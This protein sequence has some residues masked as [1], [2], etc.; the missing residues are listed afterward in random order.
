MKVQDSFEVL[1]GAWG[2]L[3]FLFSLLQSEGV[4]MSAGGLASRLVPTLTKML[5][6]KPPGRTLL[7]HSLLQE[8]PLLPWFVLRGPTALLCQASLPPLLW[9]CAC[10][11]GTELHLTEKWVF[12]Q[13]GQFEMWLVEV[14]CQARCEQPRT[15]G[16]RTARLFSAALPA[17]VTPAL[18]KCWPQGA[19]S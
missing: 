12:F 3:F 8:H 18:M 5:A 10:D 4:L 6:A 9:P 14:V 19:V 13:P 2:C 16:G 7:S 1:G 17:D 11:L 15:V